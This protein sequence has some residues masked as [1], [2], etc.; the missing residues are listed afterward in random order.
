MRRAGRIVAIVVAVTA[1][2]PRPAGAQSP[3]S[4]AAATALFD[5]GRQLMDQQRWVEACP[6]LA[7]SEQLAPS[8]GTLIN[9]AECYEHTGQTASAWVAWKG[10]AA[11]ANA[12]GKRDIERNSLG[13][14][15]ALEPAL[16]R[17]TIAVEAAS[18][19]E[20]LVVKRDG[21]V[22]G[23]TELGMGIP[24]DPGV[25]V[26]EASAPKKK[27]LSTKVDVSASQPSTQVNVRLE[28]EPAVVGPERVAPAA[29]ATKPEQPSPRPAG[30][31]S[32]T[33]RTIGLV[34]GA[35][36]IAGIGVGT[37]F[38]L[39]AK[40]KNDEALQPANCRTS[41]YC[42]REGLALTSDAK[43][44]AT[45]STIA[46][47]VGAAAIAAGAVLWLTAPASSMT[48]E[49][50]LAPVVSQSYRGLAVDATW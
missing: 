49:I 23:R 4:E 6:K 50:R 22:V 12:A 3:G 34:V 37:A 36:G 11:R 25:H 28:D 42:T 46:F 45:V 40:S 2:T 1:L 31:P 18:D 41:A 8:G 44:A 10:A 14:A 33:Q 43:N 9:L 47:G 35:T 24:V 39:I 26:V 13:R 7:E 30:P 32:G 27:T 16:A 21:V 15:A 48:G 17:L 19:V 38:G 20:G 29:P 5:D